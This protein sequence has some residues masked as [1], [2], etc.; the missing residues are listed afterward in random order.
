MK[1]ARKNGKKRNGN[2]VT[3]TNLIFSFGIALLSATI[4]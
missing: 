3:F 2:Q 1:R 4:D